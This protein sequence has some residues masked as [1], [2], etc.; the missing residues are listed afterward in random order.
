MALLFCFFNPQ[1]NAIIFSKRYGSAQDR[2]CPAPFCLRGTEVWP[3]SRFDKAS[4]HAPSVQQLNPANAIS[5]CPPFN[6]E[7][8]P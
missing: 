8:F 1:L 6:K 2:E 7:R 4:L 5:N 3:D